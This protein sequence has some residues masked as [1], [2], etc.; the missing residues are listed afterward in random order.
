LTPITPSNSNLTLVST[1]PLLNYITDDFFHTPRNNNTNI[2][3]IENSSI[4]STSDIKINNIIIGPNP[5]KDKIYFNEKIMAKSII[6]YDVHGNQLILIN[7][8]SD[9]SIDISKL[10][11]GIYFLIIIDNN[12]NTRQYKFTII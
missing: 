12:K 6:V 4:T 3:A 10:K 1:T 9:D 5:A 8:F 11:S 7:D 2:G